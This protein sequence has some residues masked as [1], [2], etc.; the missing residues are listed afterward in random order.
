MF[1]LTIEVG[2]D[3]KLLQELVYERV[4]RAAGLTLQDHAPQTH[5]K[6]QSELQPGVPLLK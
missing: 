4:R 5:V 3:D 1:K 6:I 2:S